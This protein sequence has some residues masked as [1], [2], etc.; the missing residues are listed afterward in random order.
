MATREPNCPACRTA[1]ERG[2][3]FDR[4]QHSSGRQAEWVQGEPEKSF[5]V[6]LKTKGRAVIPIVSYR[7]RSCGMLASFATGAKRPGSA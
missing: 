7:C 3:L 4:T 5:W 6:G 1:M 2:Y